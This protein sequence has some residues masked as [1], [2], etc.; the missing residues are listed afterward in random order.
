LRPSVQG[1]IH[2]NHQ[3]ARKP[4]GPQADLNHSIKTYLNGA[5]VS[6]IVLDTSATTT[7]TIDYSTHISR[8]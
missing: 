6:D 4:P 5:L 2:L 8:T 1:I 7:D 3:D